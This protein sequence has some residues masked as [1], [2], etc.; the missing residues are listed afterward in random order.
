MLQT[1][2]Q[3]DPYVEPHLFLV[4]PTFHT[5]CAISLNVLTA[6][7]ACPNNVLFIAASSSCSSYGM[8]MP[9]AVRLKLPLDWSF[10]SGAYGDV[11]TVEDAAVPRPLGVGHVES[12]SSSG[13]SSSRKLCDGR[14]GRSVS[15]DEVFLR[16][17]DGN[18]ENA[19]GVSGGSGVSFRYFR[20]VDGRGSISLVMSLKLPRG[21]DLL[22][23]LR[24]GSNIKPPSSS[25]SVSSSDE[26][27]STTAVASSS[28]ESTACT[29]RTS[30]LK[31]ICLQ[32]DGV[33]R[34]DS[35]TRPEAG[36]RAVGVGA[37][38]DLIY[39]SRGPS[40]PPRLKVGRRGAGLDRCCF[41]ISPA[42][43]RSVCCDL[44]RSRMTAEADFFFKLDFFQIQ[45]DEVDRR[46]SGCDCPRLKL[47]FVST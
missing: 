19:G 24:C 10:P 11:Y 30:S 45:D 34:P 23:L 17:R 38:E 28:S 44:D 5:T 42:R 12:S 9:D 47:L 15:C 31:E 22:L 27:S 21:V 25:S 20:V 35:L 8:N 4:Q 7:I 6:Y 3:N 32:S 41:M 16:V 13:S 2:K 18:Q 14:E 46:L 33:C 39:C 37:V 1:P 36:S 29:C 26:S 43:C 40:E